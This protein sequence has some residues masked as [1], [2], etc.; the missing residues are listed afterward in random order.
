MIYPFKATI[1]T[2]DITRQDP[3]I[4]NLL[5]RQGACKNT[6]DRDKVS[7]LDFAKE[8]GWQQGAYMI[9]KAPACGTI[10]N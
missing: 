1:I 7:P 3:A 2:P 10:K 9:E 5:L 6:V 8:V 4:L